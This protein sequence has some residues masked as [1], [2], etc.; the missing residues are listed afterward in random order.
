MRRD[1]GTHIGPPALEIE[2]HIGHPLS[3]PVIGVFA[4]AAGRVHLEP[5]GRNQVL[6]L[7]AGAG[8][9]ERR[10][11][12]QPDQLVGL[13]RGNAPGLRFHEGHGFRVGG[14]SL[15]Y[16]PSD[17]RARALREKP[18]LKCVARI[19]GPCLDPFGAK[20]NSLDRPLCYQAAVRRIL[21]CPAGP[22]RTVF[23]D[24]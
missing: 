1:E 22:V 2:H 6:G 12:N 3:R 20:G 24:C 15:R 16:P 13:A 10:M 21:S 11:L 19:H 18:G 4:A 7:G 17:W 9:V 14:Q 23:C 8:R 5:V